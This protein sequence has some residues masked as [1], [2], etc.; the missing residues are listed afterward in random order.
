M[1]KRAPLVVSGVGHHRQPRN[2]SAA[3]MAWT[4]SRGG[5]PARSRCRHVR[6]WGVMFSYCS[7]RFERQANRY[8]VELTGDKATFIAALEKLAAVNCMTRKWSKWDIFQTRPDIARRVHDCEP[9]YA[10]VNA[11]GVLYGNDPQEASSHQ[12]SSCY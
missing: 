6:Y 8:A 7:R 3:A 2:R 11:P 10:R 1:K 9:G 5:W 4:R 12:R